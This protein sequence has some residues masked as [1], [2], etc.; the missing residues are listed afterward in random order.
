MDFSNIFIQFLVVCI[1]SFIG[2]LLLQYL[3]N[4]RDLQI[5]QKQ[6]AL[7]VLNDLQNYCFILSTNIKN[8]ELAL[9]SSEKGD[10]GHLYP[11]F[12]AFQWSNS[13]PKLNF[14]D[15]VYILDNNIVNNLYV[16]IRKS[17]YYRFSMKLDSSI[18]IDVVI[19]AYPD[20]MKKLVLEGI[21]L[22]QEIAKKY[23]LPIKDEVWY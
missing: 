18:D 15:D 12:G 2:P 22:S 19:E 11:E 5:N 10:G 7:K 8:H 17:E 23:S 9:R 6:V 14:S 21:E 1:G 3:K 4:K 20:N 13:I 16:F